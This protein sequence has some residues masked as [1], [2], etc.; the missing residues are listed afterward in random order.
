M[1]EEYH[2]AFGRTAKNACIEP[3]SLCLA[4]LLFIPMPSL[5]STSLPPKMS[6]HLNKCFSLTLCPDHFMHIV[7]Y[8]NSAAPI[9]V[10]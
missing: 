2:S 4:T 10:Y 5:T 1:R 6:L 7:H 8:G 3:C 9:N